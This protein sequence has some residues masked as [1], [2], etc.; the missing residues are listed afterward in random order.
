MPSDHLTIHRPFSFYFRLSQLQSLRASKGHIQQGHVPGSPVANV[1]PAQG[2][3]VPSLA[4][5]L[6]LKCRNQ[7]LVQAEKCRKVKTVS[8]LGPHLDQLNRTS[9]LF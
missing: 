9:I 7:H 2:A 1:A 4:R 3:G 5:E 8:I 6:G